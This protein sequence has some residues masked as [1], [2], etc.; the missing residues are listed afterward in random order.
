MTS[1]IRR[2][3]RALLVGLLAGTLALGLALAACGEKAEPDPGGALGSVATPA[4]AEAAASC[5]RLPPPAGG[6]G[7]SAAEAIRAS[8]VPGVG[9]GDSTGEGLSLLLEGSRVRPGETIGVAVRNDSRESVLYGLGPKL[10]NAGTGAQEPTGTG[11]VRSIGLIA[12]P[13]EIGPCTDLPVLNSTAPGRY[14][15]VVAASGAR[16]GR[17]PDLE[18]TAEIVVAGEPLDPEEQATSGIDPP[19]PIEVLYE[20]P[21]AFAPDDR[22][23]PG[24]PVEV[25][26]GAEIVPLEAAD[27]G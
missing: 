24:P 27:A 9:E 16:G 26:L 2:P 20:P 13:G 10:E 6:K 3:Q 12:A 21:E 18:I 15:V 4:A 11:V 5:E 14:R 22:G 8:F 17:G 23:L 25:T 7:E 19:S 1:P